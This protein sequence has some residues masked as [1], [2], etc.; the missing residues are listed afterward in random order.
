MK[1]NK[2]YMISYSANFQGVHFVHKLIVVL[3]ISTV[4]YLLSIHRA[5]LYINE[6]KIQEQF[7]A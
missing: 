2:V 1:M 6:C 5:P 7:N 4:Q 3:S